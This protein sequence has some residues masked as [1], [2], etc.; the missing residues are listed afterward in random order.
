MYHGVT[1]EK[2]RKGESL[3]GGQGTINWGITMCK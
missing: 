1:A 3:L 2:E